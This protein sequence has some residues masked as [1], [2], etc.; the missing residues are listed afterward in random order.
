MQFK[1][2][3]IR[4]LNREFGIIC[5]NINGPCPLLALVNALIL[6]NRVFIHPDRSFVTLE[7]LIEIIA[8][9]YVEGTQRAQNKDKL[10]LETQKQQLNDV[11]EILPSLAHGLDLNVKFDNIFS[12]EFT[13]ELS[14]F[15]GLDIPVVH[16]WV[17]DPQDKKSSEVF[18]TF[19]YNHVINQLVEYKT[20]LE[21]YKPILQIKEVSNDSKMADI[22]R[23]QHIEKMKSANLDD[24]NLGP[25]EYSTEDY[26]PPN[27]RDEVKG[28]YYLIPYKEINE[29]FCVSRN[30][31]ISF[32]HRKE[33]LR[34]CTR[35]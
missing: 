25:K 19:S 31:L 21:K 34:I 4:F 23:D 16:G 17:V 35:G 14:V 22:I 3:P 7:S 33:K 30:E 24:A 27:I 29:N 6:Q 28:T 9:C 5:Q 15:D 26:V 32:I 2:K 11:L 1:I 13:K 8:N 18:K 12:F 10:Y 20:L